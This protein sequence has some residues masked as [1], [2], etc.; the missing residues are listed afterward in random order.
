[1]TAI[2][3][4]KNIAETRIYQAGEIIYE[5]GDA[6]DHMYAVRQGAVNILFNGEVMETIEPCGYFGEKSLIDDTPHTT[7]AV[8]KTNCVIVPVNEDR[9]LYLVHETPMF[10]LSMMRTMAA[11]TRR[12][13]E[14]AMR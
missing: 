13:A 3:Y 2:D 6:D 5:V 4:F 11:R 7:T 10:A 14:M 12:I 8:A 1:M 9:F